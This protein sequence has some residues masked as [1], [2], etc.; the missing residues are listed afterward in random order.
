MSL[1]YDLNGFSLLFHFYI[2]QVASAK[3]ISPI[4]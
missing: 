1:Y 4:R 2:V 3:H